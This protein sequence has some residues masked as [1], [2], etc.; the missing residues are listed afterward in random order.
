[1]QKLTDIWQ[2]L[3]R[4]HDQSPNQEAVNQESPIEDQDNQEA[5]NHEE[6]NQEEH[7]EALIDEQQYKNLYWT[8]VVSMQ[9]AMEERISRKLMVDHI[10]EALSAIQQF[11]EQPDWE[12]LFDP[13]VFVR[14]ND[15]LAI[16]NYEMNEEELHSWCVRG[17]NIR[18]SIDQR[19]EDLRE[20]E[21]D[22]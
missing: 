7:N 2:N 11:E 20:T 8:G 16:A 21:V 5:S 14:S 13:S 9:R 6:A 3:V 19:V 17:I 18:K 4:W 22:Y 1:M 10:I 12:P 15:E